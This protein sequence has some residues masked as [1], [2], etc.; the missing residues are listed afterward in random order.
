[1]RFMRLNPRI[2]ILSILSKLFFAA[3]LYA[4]CV[5]CG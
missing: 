5:L 3:F 1:M 4:L 2:I